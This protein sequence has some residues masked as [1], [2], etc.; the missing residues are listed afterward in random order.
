MQGSL[1]AIEGID[2]S[3]KTTV[4]Q[5]LPERLRI[6]GMDPILLSRKSAAGVTDPYLAR[7]MSNLSATIWGATLTDPVQLVPEDT[8]L[9]LHAAWYR[10]FDEIILAPLL[11]AGKL[12]LLDGWYFKFLA[13]HRAHGS[14]PLTVSDGL[15]ARVVRP[16]VTVL[17]DV[18]PEICW[19]RR[20]VYKPSELGAHAG[21][22]A[23]SPYEAFLKYQHAVRQEYLAL[24]CAADWRVIATER[25]SSANVLERSVNAILTALAARGQ[26]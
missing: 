9:C 11:Q 19:T 22:V 23:A 17:L 18:A 24:A 8:W 5:G 12:V 26:H 10:L 25:E 14:V 15:L 4:S 20:A 6:S 21:V 13:R 2:G 16:N 3:G 1:V 7:V